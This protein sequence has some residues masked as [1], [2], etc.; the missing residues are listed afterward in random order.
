[1]K[2]NRKAGL[3]DGTDVI[4]GLAAGLIGGLVASWMMNQFQALLSNIAKNDK[5]SEDATP[6]EKKREDDQESDNATV[7]VASAISEN[8]F[9]HKLTRSEKKIAGPAV[10]YAFGTISGGLYGAAAEFAPAMTIGIGVPFGTIMWLVADEAV[11]PTLGLAE[12]PTKYPLSTHAYALTSHFVY[13]LTA[14]IM[15]RV[16]RRVL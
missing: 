7:K 11:V 2:Q 1:M 5:K 10:H 12:F 13:G 4:K 8:I 14:E 9:D 3:P 6:E 16:I 15:R